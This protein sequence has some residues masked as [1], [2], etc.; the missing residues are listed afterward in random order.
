MSTIVRH[1]AI[2][3]GAPIDGRHKALTVCGTYAQVVIG[4][5]PQA[6]WAEEVGGM[7]DGS[8]SLHCQT[9]LRLV[10]NSGPVTAARWPSPIVG[11]PVERP[12]PYPLPWPSPPDDIVPQALAS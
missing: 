2:L 9:C 6:A 10:R 11:G 5:F 8:R 4:V 12:E 7:S 1:H 3:P